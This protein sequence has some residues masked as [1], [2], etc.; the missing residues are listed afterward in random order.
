M[1]EKLIKFCNSL[2]IEYV[3]IAPAEPYTD[4]EKIWRKQIERG[5][6]SGFEKKDVSR[7][8]NPKLTLE[9]A[10][11]VIVCLFP[12]YVGNVKE[13]KANLS[14]Y[15]YGL[16]YHLIIKEKLETIGR[17]LDENI[18]NFHYKCFVDNGPFSDRYLAYKAGLGFWGINNHII[19]EKYG[20]Y[21]FIGYIINNYPFEADTPQNKTCCQCFECVRN[22]PGQ[23]ILGDF[24]INPLRCK[25][26]ITQKK[27][28]LSPLEIEI[29]KKNNLIWGC[30]V[31]Q[32]V[33]PHNRNAE[34]TIMDEFKV[35]LK[36]Y[37]EYE[38]LLHLSNK[39]F[40]K[41]Y[42]NR[43]YSWRGKSILMRNYEI[44]HS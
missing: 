12:Y 24:T 38:E 26:Y 2:N 33:C 21:V 27:K 17:F 36:P 40:L 42:G 7:R 30:D 29:M 8:V 22:C 4:F 35:N 41:K 6:I 15:T 20:S 1:K 34:K 9:D 25:S 19:T 5:Y 11:S 44:I 3:G 14:K 32:D 16:D 23:C 39:E 43:A 13:N 31:C 18:Q 37:I 28:E 10:K